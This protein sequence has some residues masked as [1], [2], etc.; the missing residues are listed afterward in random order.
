MQ[1]CL[2]GHPGVSRSSR[3]SSPGGAA[4]QGPGPFRGFVRVCTVSAVGAPA[5]HWGEALVLGPGLSPPSP[6]PGPPAR[7]PRPGRRTAV[8]FSG[9]L[10]ACPGAASPR[11]SRRLGVMGLAA[12]PGDAVGDARRLDLFA[13]C[14]GPGLG[15]A[16]A[17]RNR[18][19]LVGAARGPGL[20]DP[21]GLAPGRPGPPPS[22]PGSPHILPLLRPQGRTGLVTGD[23]P[24]NQWLNNMRSLKLGSE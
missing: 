11:P 17:P 13:Y 18:E 16:A 14:P 2:R 4:P 12:P 22:W 20:G 6:R 21:V 9:G 19:P 7:W 23:E 24:A 1:P 15:E 8:Q 3:P 10:A 5:P